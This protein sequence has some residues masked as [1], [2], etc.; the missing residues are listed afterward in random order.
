VPWFKT[1]ELSVSCFLFRVSC[2]GSSAESGVCRVFGCRKAPARC[3]V[4]R[5]SCFVFS[6]LSGVFRVSNAG[7]HLHGV[8]VFWV[9]GVGKHLHGDHAAEAVG[10]AGVVH[11]SPE[12][13][14]PR[15]L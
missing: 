14:L 11:V 9:S 6:A 2:L 8:R 1:G 3:L 4:L 12:V 13:A 15:L 5:V 7:T 10:V